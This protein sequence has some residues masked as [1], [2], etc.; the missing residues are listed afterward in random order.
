[1]ENY[2]LTRWDPFAPLSEMSRLQD[3][4]RQ[5]QS[6]RPAVDIVEHPDAFEV[7]AEVPGMKAEDIHLDVEKNV[8][9]LRGERHL[10][11]VTEK[12]DYKRVE[13]SYGTF[14]RSFTLPETVDDEHIEAKLNEGV[15]TVRLPK[16]E[17]P[18]ARR[19][20]VSG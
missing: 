2:M 11:E 15:L 20:Q 18:S 10:E 8:L 3:L 16:R 12:S 13:R 9:T 4:A 6:F 17:A 19:I 5:S 7:R 14:T 1:M